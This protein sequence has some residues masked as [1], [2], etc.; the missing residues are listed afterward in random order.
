MITEVSF[1]FYSKLEEIKKM[2]QI[3]QKCFYDTFN[4]GHSYNSGLQFQ[5]K[6]KQLY[7]QNKKFAQIS[8]ESASCH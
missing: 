8:E 7:L 3:K 6:E 2:V 4:I 1:V 5:L